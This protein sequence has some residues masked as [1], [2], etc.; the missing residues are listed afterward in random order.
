MAGIK[1]LIF[2]L[3]DTIIHVQDPHPVRLIWEIMGKTNMDMYTFS[4]E[5]ERSIMT[6][7]FSSMK[8]AFT[9]L[10][11]GFCVEPTQD[12][13]LQISDVWTK[14]MNKLWMPGEIP[15]LLEG[16]GKKFKMGLLTNT[17]IFSYT[18]AKTKF[19]ISKYFD[20]ML[21]SYETGVIKPD[22]K[23]FYMMLEKFKLDPEQACMVGDNLFN[24]I[25]PAKKLN[26]KTVYI[27]IKNRMPGEP[28]ADMTVKTMGQLIKALDNLK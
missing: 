17:D 15:P 27:D 20:H 21:A 19:E 22:R 14:T 3:W 10:L 7:P 18:Y 12:I 4:L 1:L 13:I 8:E 23:P 25:I 26:M 16:L 6:K 28:H 2:D 24:D 9:E 5:F 11:E